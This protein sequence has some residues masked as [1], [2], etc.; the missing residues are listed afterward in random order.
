[1]RSN[2]FLQGG[3]YNCFHK[4]FNGIFN[5]HHIFQVIRPKCSFNPYH[6]TLTERLQRSW[7]RACTKTI[8]PLA[9]ANIY[10]L[11]LP[12]MTP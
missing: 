11:A 9:N 1:M 7:Q 2:L 10:S 12:I 6:R 4:L 5:A 8:L 3:W